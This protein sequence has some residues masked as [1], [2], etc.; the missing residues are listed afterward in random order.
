MSNTLA[1]S[2]EGTALTIL[3]NIF[4][5]LFIAKQVC[6]ILGFVNHKDAVKTHCDPEDVSKVEIETNGGKQL[7]NCVNESG[8][9]ALIFGSKLPKAKQF[10]KWVTSE[11][12]P[13]IRKQG[14]YCPAL[15][16]LETLTPAQQRQIQIAVA[17]RAQK[18]AHNYQTI[19]RALKNRFQVAR[20]D[21]IPQA[22][23]KEAMDFIHIVD[24]SVPDVQKEPES[25]GEIFFYNAR[26]LSENELRA[27][28][29]LIYLR[30]L[31]K[32]TFTKIYTGL[33]ELNSELAPRF[34][35]LIAEGDFPVAA[36]KNVLERNQIDFTRPIR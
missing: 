8:L 32:P 31:G 35:S 36:L 27:L 24:L 1:F 28:A 21:Q 13:A 16:R 34:Y 5:P 20:Y 30:E 10:K 14:A 19:Y 25:T 11:V 17:A 12:L 3:G 23:F 18:T 15:E 26:A 7:V 4:D 33:R 6:E 22:Q 29:N 2:F 9:Y